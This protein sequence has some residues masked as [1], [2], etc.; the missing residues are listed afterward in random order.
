MNQEAKQLE[1]LSL[2][3]FKVMDQPL[4]KGQDQ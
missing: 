4:I 2:T 1:G 3:L